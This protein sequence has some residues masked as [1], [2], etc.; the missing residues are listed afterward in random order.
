M[1]SAILCV[2]VSSP[3]QADDFSPLKPVDPV[4]P[5][6]GWSE[7]IPADVDGDGDQDLIG[8]TLEGLFGSP[9]ASCMIGWKENDGS[10]AFGQT[11][12]I[13]TYPYATEPSIADIDGDGTSDLLT[14]VLGS[15]S[16]EVVYARGLGQGTFASP[17]VLLSVPQAICRAGALDLD[18]D[19]VLDL[20][21]SVGTPFAIQWSR[22]L[23][24]A[25]FAAPVSLSQS[26]SIA[27]TYKTFGVDADLDGDMDLVSGP[28][29]VFNDGGGNLR[30]E[31][32]STASLPMPEPHCWARVWW[33]PTPRQ[34]YFDSLNVRIQGESM[35][36]FTAMSTQRIYGC[37]P[38]DVDG[39]GLDEIVV[40][41]FPTSCAFNPSGNV[42]VLRQGL[43]NS[44]SE[45][46]RINNGGGRQALVP[47]DMD[48][49]G[50]DDLVISRTCSAASGGWMK[51][52]VVEYSS[53]CQPTTNSAGAFGRLVPDGSSDLSDDWL[54]LT[55]TRLP[56]PRT[57]FFLFSQAQGFSAPF[58]SG[59]LCLGGPI[60]RLSNFPLSS[61][62]SNGQG[63]VR[64]QVP[65]S[66]LPTNATWI[67]GETWNF[68]YWHREPGSTSNTTDAASIQ[69]R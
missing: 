66:G 4:N 10:G 45:L 59:V 61:A 26:Q 22:G 14:V 5:T 52:Y 16:P 8:R 19:G 3:A 47:A 68:Q 24:G 33:S 34:I 62:G 38:F 29:R 56:V 21:L 6:S 67:A 58:G 11:H 15:S 9:G 54:V 12:L 51:S 53:Y 41:Q 7:L 60:Y 25:A 13:G 28:H 49:D 35:N 55:A 31:T 64:L 63:H 50:Y 30:F 27:G 18:G 40:S 48:G 36:A 57:G 20:G 17:S 42:I 23:G 1:Y 44:W 37:A 69:F 43:S 65:Q 2:L 39:D 46:Y 32:Q